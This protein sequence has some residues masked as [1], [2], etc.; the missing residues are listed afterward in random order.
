[1]RRDGP[2]NL[3][4]VQKLDRSTEYEQT[5]PSCNAA[6]IYAPSVPVAFDASNT[7][8]RIFNLAHNVRHSHLDL[9]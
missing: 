7:S 5:L 1:M 3:N 4:A 9:R 2:S 8:L 6:S